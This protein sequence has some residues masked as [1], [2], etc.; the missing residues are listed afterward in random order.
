MS[1]SHLLLDAGVAAT[2]ISCCP[3]GRREEEAGC[4]TRRESPTSEPSSRTEETDEGCFRRKLQACPASTLGTL[5]RFRSRHRASRRR[6]SFPVWSGPP[7]EK[8]GDQR[9]PRGEEAQGENAARRQGCERLQEQETIQETLT[10]GECMHPRFAAE[11]RPQYSSGEDA[12]E[13]HSR[14]VPH[15]PNVFCVVCDR[16]RIEKKKI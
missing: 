16:E 14:K 9:Q 15:F 13:T 10:G 3:A 11:G 2:L 4:R 5:R 8:A 12:R 6:Y 7:Q 1:S